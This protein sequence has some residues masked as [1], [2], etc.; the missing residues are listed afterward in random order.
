[1]IDVMLV[2]VGPGVSANAIAI[3]KDVGVHTKM[4]LDVRNRVVSP[5][6]IAERTASLEIR[7]K[8]Q[9]ASGLR[10]GRIGERVILIPAWPKPC[11]VNR[12]A[13][14]GENPGVGVA[15]ADRRI[16]V[17]DDPVGLGQ[18][19]RCP[20]PDLAGLPVFEALKV[21]TAGPLGV[22]VF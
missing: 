17:V 6:G 22:R 10:G 16:G 3:N 12:G 14:E 19:E 8:L 13:A 5:T 11:P 18:E 4:P 2:L 21:Q 1:M 20:G 15:G 7:L 9:L